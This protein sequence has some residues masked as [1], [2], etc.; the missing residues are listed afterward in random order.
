MT[1]HKDSTIAFALGFIEDFVE[2]N[3]EFLEVNE[4]TMTEQQ[5]LAASNENEHRSQ[6]HAMMKVI[7]DGIAQLMRENTSLRTK[8]LLAESALK[9]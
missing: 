4:E 9:G 6:V 5:L 8:I 7:S 2:S 3:S 1:Q